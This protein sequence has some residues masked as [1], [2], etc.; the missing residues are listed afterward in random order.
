MKDWTE[1]LLTAAATIGIVVLF[2]FAVQRP[3]QR[4]LQNLRVQVHA[5]EQKL[6]DTQR[7]CAV[8]MPLTRQVEVLRASAGRIEQQLPRD[9]RVGPFLQQV[10]EYLRKAH[11][12]SLEMRPASPVDGPGRT[13]LPIKM[14]FAG[15]F[16]NIF[17]FLGQ[18]ES[19]ARTKRIVELN[20]AGEPGA[21][22]SVRA[23][24]LLSIY[25]AKG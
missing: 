8:L 20:L 25:S 14:G 4:S 19:L 22:D 6:T 21:A 16:C 18:L 24:I 1:Q 12:S 15:K 13:E 5:M 11:L 17:A 9:G 3:R 7:Q 10:G 2:V 23:D